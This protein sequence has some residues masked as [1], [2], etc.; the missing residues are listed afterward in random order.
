MKTL[1]CLTLLV[2][3]VC[4]SL[5]AQEKGPKISFETSLIDYGTI[6]NGSEGKRSFSFKNTGD[7]ELIIKNV[8]SSCGCTIP[9][10][11]DAPIIP[12]EKSEIIVKYDTNRQGPFRKTITV[13]TNVEDMPI[14]ALKIKG[15]GLPKK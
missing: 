7:Q 6:E 14:I 13:S 5:Y 10:K 12:G 4:I 15:I 8:R 11:P 1:H 9:K 2:F 3:F